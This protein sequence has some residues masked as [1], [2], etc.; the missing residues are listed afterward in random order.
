MENPGY[1]GRRV[2]GD[3]TQ[4]EA[5]HF[6]RKRSDERLEAGSSALDSAYSDCD[7]RAFNIIELVQELSVRL[8]P[9]LAQEPPTVNKEGDRVESEHSD[10]PICQLLAGLHGKLRGV[11]ARL[12][13]ILDRLAV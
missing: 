13:S 8:K 6:M 5:R 2:E 3:C 9:V 11:E 7:R 1:E 4:G 12:R 10:A